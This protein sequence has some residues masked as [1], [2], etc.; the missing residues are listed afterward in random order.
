ML[1]IL[2][3][4]L[5]EYKKIVSSDFVKQLYISTEPIPLSD[6]PKMNYLWGERAHMEFTKLE[7]LDFAS[8]IYG[9]PPENFG[10]L[11]AAALKQKKENAAAVSAAAAA[12]AASEPTEWIM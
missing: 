6:P 4:K 12:A 1:N 2:G 9:F 8:K 10:S 11:Y 3:Y 5:E 7:I